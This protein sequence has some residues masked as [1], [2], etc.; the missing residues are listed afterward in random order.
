MLAGISHTEDLVPTMARTHRLVGERD[1]QSFTLKYSKSQDR[2]RH[3]FHGHKQG[4]GTDQTGAKKRQ[5]PGG[6]D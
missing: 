2:A 3:G 6:K 1:K 5:T 4:R